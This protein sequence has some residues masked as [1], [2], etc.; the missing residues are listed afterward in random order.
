MGFRVLVTML[1]KAEGK[2]GRCFVLPKVKAVLLTALP[3]L[4]G[5]RSAVH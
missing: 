5:P 1:Q 3:S 4:W 2:P